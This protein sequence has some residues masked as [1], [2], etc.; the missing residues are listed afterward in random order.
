MHKIWFERTLPPKYADLLDGV[1]VSIGSASENPEIPFGSISEAQAIIAGGRFNYDAAI[2]DR[3]PQLRVIARTGIGLDNVSLSAATARGVAVCNAPDAPTI[4]TAEHTIALI[5]AVAK[6]LK[7]IDR[8]LGRA[9]KQDY[10]N[11][12]N[13]FELYGRRL[14]LIGLGRIGSRVGELALGLGMKVSGFDPLIPAEQ[15]ARRGFELVQALETLLGQADVVSLHVPLLPE[16]RGMID[17]AR[18]AQM[19]QGAILINAA[20]GGLVDEKAL[21]AALEKG[22]LRGAGLDVFESEPPSPDHPLLARADVIATPHIAAA[23]GASKDRLWQTAIGQ[24]LQ[25]LGGERPA[26]LANPEVWP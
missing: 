14:G 10:F 20:R 19:K 5:F 7:W 23:T 26:H 17:A 3:A 11:D 1:A 6:Q 21:L 2:M 9:G 13:G 24:A 25:V 4:S 15:A 16:T 8:A 12:Y 18:L 22:R